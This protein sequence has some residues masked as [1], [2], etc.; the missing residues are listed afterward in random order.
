MTPEDLLLAHRS[1]WKKAFSVAHSVKRIMRGL[2]TLRPGA[3]CLS[4]FMNSFYMYKRIRKNYP[5][6]MNKHPAAHWEEYVPAA[7]KIPQPEHV[8]ALVPEPA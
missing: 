5:V 7:K 6:D 8:T 2:L 3:M 4:L 1:L